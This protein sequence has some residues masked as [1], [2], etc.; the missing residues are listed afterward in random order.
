MVWL[1]CKS[2]KGDRFQ[3]WHRDLSLCGKIT[4][5]IV[6]NLGIKEISD[7][8]GEDNSTETA[9][10]GTEVSLCNRAIEMKYCKQVSN[11]MKAIR[12]CGRAAMDN[13]ARKGIRFPSWLLFYSLSCPMPHGN[14]L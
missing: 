2:N 12:Q 1:I 11:A 8:K 4:K 6:V 13:G 5:T 7:S 14:S 9:V 10:E 3:G